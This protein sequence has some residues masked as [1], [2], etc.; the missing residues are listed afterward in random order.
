VKRGFPLFV[1]CILSQR[2]TGFLHGRTRGSK[3]STTGERSSPSRPRWRCSVW[4]CWARR[5]V[6]FAARRSR[7]AHLP[8]ARVASAGRLRPALFVF[9]SVVGFSLRYPKRTLKG[10][11]TLSCHVSPI[12]LA[13]LAQLSVPREHAEIIGKIGDASIVTRYP[14]DLSEALTEYTEPMARLYLQHSKEVLRWI[15]EQLP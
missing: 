9:L 5:A 13:Q 2:Q 10:V 4:D 3:K 6:C 14:Q 11:A 8:G 15:K 1:G 7:L 12:L